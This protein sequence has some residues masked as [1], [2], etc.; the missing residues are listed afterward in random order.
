MSFPIVVI[1]IFIP[2][3]IPSSSISFFP[4]FLSSFFFFLS[5]LSFLSF[6]PFF[7]PSFI[8]WKSKKVKLQSLLGSFS[9]PMNGKDSLFPETPIE[10]TNETNSNTNSAVSSGGVEGVEGVEGGVGEQKATKSN[11]LYSLLPNFALP[12]FFNDPNTSNASQVTPNRNNSNNSSAINN[13]A[14]S[15]NE[16]IKQPGASNVANAIRLFLRDF[17]QNPPPASRQPSVVRNFLE[18]TQKLISFHPLWSSCS[19]QQLDDSFEAL[20]RVVLTKVYK[21]VFAPD[22]SLLKQD[23]ELHQLIE[24][25]QFLEPKHLDI[26]LDSSQ[27]KWLEFAVKELN[28]INN[29]KGPR[30]KLVCILN[31]S[32]VVYK[33]ISGTEKPAGADEFLPA[34]I[35]VVIKANPI[36]LLANLAFIDQYREPNKMVEESSY[37]FTQIVSVASFLK[38]IQPDSLS[39]SKQEFQEKIEK[40]RKARRESS[41]TSSNSSISSLEAPIPSHIRNNSLTSSPLKESNT[42]QS[43]SQNN[44]SET[45]TKRKLVKEIWE[46]LNSGK[47]QQPINSIFE[48]EHSRLDDL[49]MKDIPKLLTA[50]KRMLNIFRS[51]QLEAEEEEQQK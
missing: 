47:E 14:N 2:S 45:Y 22:P 30:D 20:E 16:R 15:F 28:N 44:S 6:F 36:N 3:C 8:L 27:L 38:N 10:P 51:V 37:Y 29:F 35:Y 31:C 34:L 25:L 1:S 7:L 49:R 21:I 33:M 46:K 13:E 19:P 12:S 39:I 26:Q 18:E 24:D 50:Y 11:S 48:F 17:S 9:S 40:S 32:K 23:R 43:N 4:F 42:T 41:S 5:F